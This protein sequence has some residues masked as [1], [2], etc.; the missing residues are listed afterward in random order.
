LFFFSVL[1]NSS[2]SENL[3]RLY[4][5]ISGIATVISH[6]HSTTFTSLSLFA[7][8]IN[9]VFLRIPR[10][11]PPDGLYSN[12]TPLSSPG[13]IRFTAT[14]S[15]F[16]PSISP[17][18]CQDLNLHFLQCRP[19]R[20]RK[21][22][23]PELWLRS[24]QTSGPQN[25]GAPGSITKSRLRISSFSLSNV[26]SRTSKPS[27]IHFHCNSG[28]HVRIQNLKS[29]I[30]WPRFRSLQNEVE[31]LEELRDTRERFYEAKRIEMRKF[32][33]IAERFVVNCRM[34]VESLRNRVNL[35]ITCYV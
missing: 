17:Q 9:G 23:S 13:P 29:L 4:S 3:F 1:Q 34:E 10:A 24:S 28:S 5:L 25:R 33:E 14:F 26:K 35:V 11:S 21:P 18:P 12:P 20:S 2:A 30:N 6:H 19:R 8:S 32:K 22:T 16:S 31:E 15:L 27:T 7:C